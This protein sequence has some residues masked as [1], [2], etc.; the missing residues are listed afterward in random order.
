MRNLWLLEH[1]SWLFYIPCTLIFPPAREP[2]ATST[3]ILVPFITGLPCL[4]FG[5]DAILVVRFSIDIYGGSVDK[6]FLYSPGGMYYLFTCATFLSLSVNVCGGGGY[7]IIFKTS[8]G[9]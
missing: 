9:V 6:Y 8:L 7:P 3:G 1:P 2:S 5:S 4:I